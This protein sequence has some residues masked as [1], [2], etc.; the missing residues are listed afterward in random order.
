MRIENWKPT[1]RSEELCQF[2][3]SSKQLDLMAIKGYIKK[4]LL[5]SLAFKNVMKFMQ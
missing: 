4:H 3:K 2:D 1:N 5:K